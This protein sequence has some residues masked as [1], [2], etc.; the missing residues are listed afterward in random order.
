MS[1]PWRRS[2]QA[3]IILILVG[4]L[5]AVLLLL[6]LRMDGLLER[7]QL[8]EAANHLQIQAMI[9][10]NSLEDPL[11]VYRHELE[12]Y[13]KD[14]DH[15]HDDEEHHSEEEEHS[16]SLSH[17]PGWAS[18]YAGETGAEVTVTDKQGRIL[19]GTEPALTSDELTLAQRGL[20]SHRWT[21]S[22]I[23][24]TALMSRGIRNIWRLRSCER[25]N[26]FHPAWISAESKTRATVVKGA[27]LSSGFMIYWP[28]INTS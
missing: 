22:T 7:A 17:L 5:G 3:R 10:A 16:G 15:D 23:H 6:N 1:W 21:S 28:R 8:D 12:E 2:I 19:V 9:A 26:R 13:E 27:V 20:P 11:S 14:H 25:T 4:L 18:S 24:A